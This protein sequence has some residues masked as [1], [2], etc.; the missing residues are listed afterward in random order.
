GDLMDNTDNFDIPEDDAERE[1]F[2]R[3]HVQGWQ[4]SGLT[5]RQYV[6]E[7]GL[8][9]ARFTY[10]KGKLF[11]RESRL[12]SSFVQVDVEPALPVR[13][14]HA[15]GVVIECAPGT[16]PSWLRGLLGFTDAS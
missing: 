12:P 5:Q 8:P 10:W 14:R 7:H 2:W 9:L 13:I 3:K 16:D 4:C 11:P 15:S 6:R 1:A